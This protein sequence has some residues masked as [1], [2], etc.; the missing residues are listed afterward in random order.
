MLFGRWRCDQARQDRLTLGIQALCA[1]VPAER[2]VAARRHLPGGRQVQPLLPSHVTAAT[3]ADTASD[4]AMMVWWRPDPRLRPVATAALAAAAANVPGAAAAGGYH[5]STAAEAPA[6]VIQTAAAA[7]KLP[8]AAPAGGRPPPAAGMPR[9]ARPRV[10]LLLQ[11]SLS[12]RIA[13][14]CS[15][16]QRPESSTQGT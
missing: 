8:A 10:P 12:V 4:L 5:G 16:G 13:T 11:E 14:S 3:A 15:A 9:L 2:Q 1:I 7:A 6:A